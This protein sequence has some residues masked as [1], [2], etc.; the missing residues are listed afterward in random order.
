MMPG[1]N[2]I[3]VCKRI[4]S[5]SKCQGIPIVAVTA[6]DTKSDLASC[7]HAGADDFISK[8]INAI[9]LDARVSS[10]LRIREQYEDIQMLSQAQGNTIDFLT[11]TLNRLR[12]NLAANFDHYKPLAG[13]LM[14]IYLLFKKLFSTTSI[15][16][17]YV[18]AG[19]SQF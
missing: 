12:D 4:K 17:M 13:I 19:V 10:M 1:M 16:Y 15:F 5:D 6:L 18:Y 9:E 11:N 3:D 7:L 8:P 14:T 2:G